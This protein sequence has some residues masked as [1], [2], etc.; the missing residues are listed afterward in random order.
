MQSHG[1]T[2]YEKLTCSHYDS[3]VASAFDGLNNKTAIEHKIPITQEKY[4]ISQVI[5][6]I[7][8]NNNYLYST[9]PKMFIALY[10]NHT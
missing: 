4:K 1:T 8:Y 5:Q 9:F 10:I 7:V 3:K 2:K 6:D